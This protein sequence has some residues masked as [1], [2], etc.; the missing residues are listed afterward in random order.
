MF[1]LSE[2][3]ELN[4]GVADVPKPCR[5]WVDPSAVAWVLTVAFKCVQCVCCRVL[6]ELHPLP[7]SPWAPLGWP[8][9][10]P[11]QQR[12]LL[13]MLSVPDATRQLLLQGRP[14]LLC[15]SGSCPWLLCAPYLLPPLMGFSFLKVLQVHF[16]KYKVCLFLLSVLLLSMS[17]V[18][19]F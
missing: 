9:L 12:A 1:I 10:L 17:K 19:P 6:P 5:S 8:G 7:A 4:A 15:N 14:L 2:N 11:L 18:G 16:L 3:C 13:P